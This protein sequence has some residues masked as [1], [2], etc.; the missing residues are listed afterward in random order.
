[1][2]K[3]V[4]FIFILCLYSFFALGQKKPISISHDDGYPLQRPLRHLIAKQQNQIILKAGLRLVDVVIRNGKF[5]SLQ[6]NP[7]E[8]YS[9]YIT[10]NS[11]GEVIVA[12]VYMYKE[13]GQ[14]LIAT[15][16]SAFLAIEP[17]PVHVKLLQN[18]LA[19]NQTLSFVLL[20]KRT[21]KP[22]PNRYGIGRFFDVRVYDEQGKLVD[23][24]PMQSS[25]VITLA[26]FPKPINFKTGYTLKFTFP[27]RDF[28]T[29][30][31]FSS[32]EIVYKL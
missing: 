25:T 27:I 20:N 2:G 17:P 26:P 18:K 6:L 19:L 22:L 12:I 9:Y 29:G 5:D 31:L 14:S 21:G 23:T 28:K 11:A 3:T 1:M 30:I 8:E 16:T 15:K 7:E 4:S 10:P 32:E 24:A 13:Q